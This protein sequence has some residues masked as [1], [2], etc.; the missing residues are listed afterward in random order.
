MREIA[1]GRVR[2]R[3]AD[4]AGRERQ[5]A[6]LGRG[7]SRRAAQPVRDPVGEEDVGDGVGQAAAEEPGGLEVAGHRGDR[8]GV[9]PHLEH[10]PTLPPA[11]QGRS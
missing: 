9:V 3:V 8:I 2:V 5:P 10:A 4:P 1:C 6:R 7:R 11:V